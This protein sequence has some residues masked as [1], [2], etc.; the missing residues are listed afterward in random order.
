VSAVAQ[1]AE[2]LRLRVVGGLAGV[3]QYVRHEEP[4]WTRDLSRLSGGRVTAD[5][6]PFDRAGVPGQEML[7]LIRL[8]VVPFGTG[9]LS[10]VAGQYPELSA[11]DLAGLNPDVQTLRKVVNAFRPALDQM[12]RE[13]HGSKLLAVYTYPAQV[14]FCTERL[15]SLQGL[16]GRRVRVSGSTQSDFVRAL[17]GTPVPIP[18]AEI[19]AGIR[20]KSADCAITGAASGQAIGLPE[21]TKTIY[22]LPISWGLA[23]FAANGEAWRALPPE[24]QSLLVQE[25]PKLEAAIWED[26]ERDSA[27]SAAGSLATLSEVR[28]LAADQALRRRIFENDVLPRWIDRCGPKCPALWD[29]TIAPVV[30]VKSPPYR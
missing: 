2:S 22:T 29:A 24:V 16:A 18:F 28:P 7:T 25:M 5:I 13:R 21:V 19:V 12:M 26:A 6:V 3:S 30:G 4:F 10:Q 17:G 14:V 23:V 15:D 1:P 9:I 20:S 8:G 27:R 11:P